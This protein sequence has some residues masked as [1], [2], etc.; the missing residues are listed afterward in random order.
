VV[1]EQLPSV[2]GAR[3]Q[4]A[5][6]GHTNQWVAAVVTLY[7]G[8]AGVSQVITTAHGSAS[9]PCASEAEPEWYFATGTTVR[10]ARDE[11]SLVN[12]YPVD[13][14]ADLS[15][16]TEQGQEQPGAFEGVVV[17]AEGLT[18][19]NLGTQLSLRQHVAVTVK[20]R[21]GRIVAFE[22]E[23]VTPPAPGAPPVG[24]VGALN[25]V[26]PVAGATLSL[27]ASESSTSWWWPEGADAPGLSE[28]Y[29]I[30]N[31]GGAPARL[32]LNLIS[33]GTGGSLD[34]SNEVTV[35][36]YGTAVVT[37]NGQPWALPDISYTTH[38]ESTNGVPVVAA[39]SIAAAAP[40]T[41]RGLG[42][43]L[44]QVEPA[45]TWLLGPGLVAAPRSPVVPVTAPVTALPYF[46]GSSFTRH[47]SNV[48]F[49]SFSPVKG[50]WTQALSLPPSQPVPSAASTQT[51]PVQT[52]LEVTDPGR[53]S[54]LVTVEDF[55]NGK[56]A[57]ANTETFDVGA[58]EQGG[59]QLPAGLSST[60]HVVSSSVPILVEEDS[61]S[62]LISTG[63]NLSPTVELGPA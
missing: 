61:Y 53:N 12:P 46:A 50:V 59:L 56:L 30:Y 47:S 1:S 26:V 7:G 32:Q 6:H 4:A 39:R 16:T 51:S 45:K 36:A 52:W 63:L 38:L 20:A 29:D 49:F 18:V 3:G 27:G 23:I 8:S 57:A 21:S 34:S 28:S 55:S 40:S 17:P 54:A 42:S 35:G 43:L 14:I 33:R 24:T 37:T 2:A 60:A 58:G 15:F 48:P 10:N 11:L 62:G 9:Q 5:R 19:L 25:A 31:P 44:G 41:Y 13:A 22:T